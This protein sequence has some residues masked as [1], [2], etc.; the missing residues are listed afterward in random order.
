MNKFYLG[1][2]VYEIT[3]MNI[4]YYINVLTQ[5]KIH[6][7]HLRKCDTYT[8]RFLLKRQDSYILR[9][10][11]LPIRFIQ[12][13]GVLYYI[14]RFFKSKVKILGVL[15][16]IGVFYYMQSHILNIK[17]TGT[18][19]QL[20]EAI[21]S[22]LEDYQIHFF[23]KKLTIEKINDIKNQLLNDYQD[24]IDWINMYQ[25]GETIYIEY[26]N[27]KA[28]DIVEKDIRTIVACKESMI[29]E[30]QI[31]SGLIVSNIHQYVNKGDILVNNAIVS[32]FDETIKVYPK[33]KVYG[34]TWYTIEKELPLN[35][36]ADDFNTLLLQI[37]QELESQ[38][39]NEAKIDKEKVL[40]YNKD[41]SKIT[42]KV[43][44]TVIEDIGCK[45]D[46]NEQNIE[47]N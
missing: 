11:D 44:Y 9:R 42:L 20:N 14:T 17:I 35:D 2:D 34:Y 37:R 47:I 21:I 43:H 10:Y 18:Q 7:Y 5:H 12:S 29:K 24:Q 16:F 31:Q 1:Y 40:H 27:K 8:Y 39:G 32:T 19:Y 45:G 28:S 33:G 23:D 36:E 38:L 22:K 25:K 26:T 15:T 30:F 4:S 6:L 13:V 41:N 46:I 3:C